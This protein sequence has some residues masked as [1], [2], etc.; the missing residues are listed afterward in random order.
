MQDQPISLIDI[1]K[2]AARWHGS[3][4]IVSR[5]IEDGRITSQTYRRT[6]KRTAQLAN[7]LS[8]FGITI[9][10]RIATM[11]WN[12]HRHVEVW[13][14]TAGTG[15]VC[16]T[17]NPR[18]F[19]TQIEFI[20]NHA[21]DRIL[22]IDADLI[23]VLTPLLP[24]L[25]SLEAV[26]IMT[27]SS[28]MPNAPST[29][30]KWLCY[31]DLLAGQAEDFDW[32]SLSNDS[33][34]SSLCYT[35]GTTGNPKGVL[36]S[37][38]STLW[39]ALASVQKDAMNVGSEDS[40]L[41]VVPMFHASSWGLAFSL[42][43]VGAK[44]ILPGAKMEGASLHE[45]LETERA[46]VSAAVPTIWNMLL[47]YLSDSGSN[48]TFLKEVVIGGSAVPR[49]MIKAFKQQ[50]GVH[51]V[52]AWGV[53][54]TSPMG[55]MN[56]P[57]SLRPAAETLEEEFDRDVAQGRPPFGVDIKIVDDEGAALR[58]DG[59]SIGKLMVRGPW[60]ARAYFGGAQ[61]VLIDGWFDTGDVATIDEYGFMTITDRSKDIIKSGGEW[62]S[63]VAIENLAVSDPSVEL[64]ACLGIED[65]KWGERPLLLVK[66]VKNAKFNE[67][68]LRRRLSKDVADWQLPD[69]IAIVDEIPLTAT[70]KI[71]KRALRSQL[72]DI[73][74]D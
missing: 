74:G 69:K 58:W 72:D 56:R 43:M 30:V 8:K 14:A 45:L 66:L 26:I 68:A 55:T 64:A 24:N 28:H 27:D 33:A 54:E 21:E 73:R 19:P 53:T 71:D 62:I 31:E 49:S 29:E 6:L 4:K 1:L 36:Y 41:V 18:L 22:F 40:V 5:R 47:S 65:A 23:G 60:T 7:A 32:K 67:S 13:Y 10:D 48:L 51:V 35:S 42:P 3:Q 17:I 59:D 9:G 11:A 57:L 25:K 70:G 34:A 44:M 37:H 46:T 38:R 50:F 52:Q 15:T 63:S 61:S 2:H 39:H 16:H 12:T 20:V